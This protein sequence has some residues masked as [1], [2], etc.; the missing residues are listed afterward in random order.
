MKQKEIEQYQQKYGEVPK[1]FNERFSYILEN[2]NM[3]EK[4]LKKM[5]ATARKLV[6]TQWEEL[7]FI[8]YFTPKATPRP[9]TGNRGTFYVKGAADNFKAFQTFIKNHQRTFDVITTATILTVDVYVPIPTSGMNNI[10]T[11]LAELKLIRPLT[12]PDWDNVGKTYSDM[13]QQHLLL[14]DSLVVDGRVRKY[15]SV[16]PRI[17]IKIKYMTKY[18]SKFN[19][20]KVE[21]WKFYKDSPYNVEEK[22][23]IE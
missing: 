18:D 15:Y 22:E 4:Q 23:H 21:S 1:D 13:I 7:D 10:E 17:E 16:K 12:K 5:S 19:K 2:I 20:R 14:D 8:V 11:I 3:T 9:R 6:R